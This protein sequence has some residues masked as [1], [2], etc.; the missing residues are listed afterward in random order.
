MTVKTAEV[1]SRCSSRLHG[2][3]LRVWF[4]CS[5]LV[6]NEHSLKLPHPLEVYTRGTELAIM[7]FWR[8][9]REEDPLQIGYQLWTELCHTEAC[10]SGSKCFEAAEPVMQRGKSAHPHPQTNRMS[11]W[12][13]NDSEK[14]QSNYSGNYC[15][16]CIFGAICKED[17]AINCITVLTQRRF[18]P[19]N[20]EGWQNA[21]VNTEGHGKP[22][23]W[24]WG[25]SCNKRQGQNH[26]VHDDD[27][28]DDDDRE[29]YGQYNN[30]RITNQLIKIRQVCTYPSILFRNYLSQL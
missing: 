28:D 17:A 27:D 19:G 24:N 12:S 3:M 26:T 29:D 7:H 25:R 30:K 4:K 14:L 11:A 18:I 15:K 16:I 21:S 8:N 1:R 22:I 10:T 2:H 6:L 13:G 9:E 5:S 20:F 23:G